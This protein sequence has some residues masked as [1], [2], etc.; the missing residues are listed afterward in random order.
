M[1]KWQLRLQPN[2]PAPGGSGSETLLES[3]LLMAPSVVGERGDY[4]HPGGVGDLLLVLHWGVYRQGQPRWIS[5]KN[6]CLIGKEL[7]EKRRKESSL[8]WPT[9]GFNMKRF[10]FFHTEKLQLVIQMFFFLFRCEKWKHQ[11]GEWR[12]KL[13]VFTLC[14]RSFVDE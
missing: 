13:V 9:S 2:T 14:K 11:T 8:E 6:Y 7:G 4:Q 12:P 1:P 3:K 10:S 5:G